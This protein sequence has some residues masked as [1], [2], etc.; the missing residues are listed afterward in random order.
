MLTNNSTGVDRDLHYASITILDM[1]IW[2][3]T[4]LYQSHYNAA[5]ITAGIT[6]L[7]YSSLT[8]EVFTY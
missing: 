1:G 5:L 2:L 3:I 8:I 4:V 6:V 7:A